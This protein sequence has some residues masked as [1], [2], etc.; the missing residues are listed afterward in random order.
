[1][2]S[3]RR[4]ATICYSSLG[5]VIAEDTRHGLLLLVLLLLLLLLLMPLPVL[6]PA[7]TA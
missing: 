6:V 2:W 5:S 3:C 7:T 1:M 4:A